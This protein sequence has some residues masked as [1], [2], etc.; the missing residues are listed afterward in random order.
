MATVDNTEPAEKLGHNHPLFLNSND[1]SGAILI[2]LQLRGLENY[3]VWSRAMRIAILELLSGIVYS[4]NASAV[5][6]DPK[7]R[8]DK[9]NCSRIF[10]IRREIDIARQGTS[11]I[12]TYFSKLRVLWTEFDSLAPIP[13]YDAA[14]SRE[15]V[16]FMERQ[17]LLHFLMGLNESYEQ[18]RSQLLMMIPVPSVNK[19]YSML[20][21]RESQKTM[22]SASTSLD[23]GEMAALLTNRV[24]N[25]Q[26][27]KKNYNLY[28]DY[29]KLKSYTRDICY[30]LVGYPND[31]KFKKKCNPQ[32]TANLA[33]EQPAPTTFTSN[34]TT[35]SHHNNTN[36]SCNCSSVSPPKL[37][38]MQQSWKHV[39]LHP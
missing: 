14:N 37:Q 29:C 15:F 17:K 38:L 32:G 21:E 24:G 23:A 13:S 16:Q 33:T 26:K 10:H 6:E 27:P 34:P 36:K 28:C 11:S 5:W 35:P 8:F 22:A 3:S 19:A 20:M 25:Q 31:H 18:A 4:S 12:S 2:S 1:N 39:L 30:K 9:V 7:E